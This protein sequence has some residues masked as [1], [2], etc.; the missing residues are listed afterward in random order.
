MSEEVEEVRREKSLAE[1]VSE[2]MQQAWQELH[3][4][5]MQQA[6]EAEE[7]WAEV[8]QLRKEEFWWATVEGNRGVCGQQWKTRVKKGMGHC[9]MM[10]TCIHH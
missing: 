7:M 9:L 5:E 3:V 1:V 4:P 8:Q 10:S 6:S 2:E